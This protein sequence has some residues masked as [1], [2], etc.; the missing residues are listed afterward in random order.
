MLLIEEEK[1]LKPNLLIPSNIVAL[2]ETN[3]PLGI[4][5]EPGHF[6]VKRRWSI[7][8]SDTGYIKNFPKESSLAFVLT[9]DNIFLYQQIKKIFQEENTKDNYNLKKIQRLLQ[10]KQHCTNGYK[11]KSTEYLKPKSKIT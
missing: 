3:T 4:Q 11:K 1:R 6:Q 2:E 5:G 10:E 9:G 7:F 8:S